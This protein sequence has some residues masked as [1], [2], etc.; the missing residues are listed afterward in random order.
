MRP[1]RILNLGAVLMLFLGLLRAAGG[2]LLLT[3]GAAIDSR[4]EASESTVTMAGAGLLVLG[5]IL[6]VA[7]VGVLLRH[8]FFWKLGIACTL[9]FVIDGAING[10][11][12]YGRPGDQGTIVNVIVASMILICLYRGAR[13][14]P[15]PA[16]ASA[17]SML[18]GA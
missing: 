13:A 2:V 9:A 17:E 16:S 7:A 11:L 3:R 14:L 1:Q 18:T 15:A 5:L 8:R 10:W 6:V 12:L 4:I